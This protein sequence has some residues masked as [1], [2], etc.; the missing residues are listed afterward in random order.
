[1]S[2]L[3]PS[4]LPANKSATTNR[5]NGGRAFCQ[6]TID[7]GITSQVWT[8]AGHDLSSSRRIL[9]IKRHTDTTKYCYFGRDL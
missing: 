8:A 1:M 4:F 2:I 5:A 6:F 3:K 7:T 9:L